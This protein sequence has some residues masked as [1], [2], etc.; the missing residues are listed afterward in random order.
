MLMLKTATAFTCEKSRRSG[1]PRPGGSREV[2]SQGTETLDTLAPQLLAGRDIAGSNH[3]SGLAAKDTPALA[4]VN[5]PAALEP[6]GSQWA[7][8]LPDGRVIP[9]GA[10]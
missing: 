2:S 7:I 5:A 1:A 9:T 3:S 6:S 8:Q 4:D 10:G